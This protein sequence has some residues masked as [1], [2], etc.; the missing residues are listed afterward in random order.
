MLV[1]EAYGW[2]TA[3]ARGASLLITVQQAVAWCVR[4]RQCGARPA[5]TPVIA[6]Q[7]W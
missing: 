7:R 3:V 4:S 1:L 5:S 6:A 2:V